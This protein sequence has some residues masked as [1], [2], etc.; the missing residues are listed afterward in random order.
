[1]FSERV[2]LNMRSKA[3]PELEFCKKNSAI[4]AIFDI[5]VIKNWRLSA[6]S[7]FTQKN[8][9]LLHLKKPGFILVTSK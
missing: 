3:N 8:I 7:I 2:D 9:I 1:M 5:G 4:C 6:E